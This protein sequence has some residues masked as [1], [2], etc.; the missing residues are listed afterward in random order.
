MCIKH[1]QLEPDEGEP[2]YVQKKNLMTTK[3]LQHTQKK[4]LT[5][6]HTSFMCLSILYFTIHPSPIWGLYEGL[7]EDSAAIVGI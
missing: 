5:T 2:L 3:Q 1:C 4:H 6:G 7:T